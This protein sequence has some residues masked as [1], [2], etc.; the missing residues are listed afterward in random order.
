MNTAIT[1]IVK[2]TTEAHQISEDAVLQTRTATEMMNRLSQ[3]THDI[4]AITESI[5]EISEQTNLLAL[6][7]TIESA[8]AGEAG[9]GFAVVANEI[10][11]W[12]NKP[13]IQPK[14]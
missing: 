11:R 3:A 13:L 6:N 14:R 8:R 12:P 10:K 2:R 1:S 7:A 5:A 4:Q 9:K